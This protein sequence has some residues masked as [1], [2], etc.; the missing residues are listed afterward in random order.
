MQL[1]RNLLRERVARV[2]HG[3]QQPFDLERGIEVRAHFLD[4]LHQV[5]QAFER[6][7]LALHRDH[8]RV[9]RGKPV[10]RQQ[11]QRRRTIDQDE[12]VVVL[13]LRKR[14]LQ[15]R[16]APLEIDHLDFGAGELAVGR[17]QVVLAAGART[18]TSRDALRRRAAPGRRVALSARLSMPLPIVALPCGSRSTSSTRRLR[19]AQARGEIDAGRGLAHA[20]FLVGD[21]E[22]AGHRPALAG[23]HEHADGARRRSPGTVSGTT[24]LDATAARQLRE[25]LVRMDA[26]HRGEHAAGRAQAGRRARRTRR[27]RRTRARSR[28]R[29]RCGGCQA[30]TRSLT[31]STFVEPELDHRLPQER[32]LLVVAVEQ[33]HAQSRPRERERNARQPRAAADVEQRVAGAGAAATARLSST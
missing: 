14:F 21:R 23:S 27:G 2:V 15:P 29:K 7:V 19:R 9:R 20:A 16:F 1:R 4:G 28:R 13:D 25:L 26:F 6:V 30:S 3:A 11:I 12:I 17:Q 22:Y 31:T 8:H 5:A 10:H 18:R 24:S 33:R 32:A